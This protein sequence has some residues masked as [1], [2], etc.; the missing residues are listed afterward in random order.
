MHSIASW[1]EAV[2]GQ[3]P[4]GRSMCRICV[5]RIVKRPICSG[6][7]VGFELGI[8]HHI[9]EKGCEVEY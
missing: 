9:N 4:R 5:P 7:W 1:V 2:A 6:V 3:R 8:T